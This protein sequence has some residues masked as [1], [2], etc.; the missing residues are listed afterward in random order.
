MAI[1]I[2]W[3]ITQLRVVDQGDLKNVAMQACF[4]VSGVDE[5]DHRGFAQGDVLLLPVSDPAKFA[6]ISTVSEEQV[7]AWVRAALGDRVSFFEGQ[8]TDQIG[9]QKQPKPQ[10]ADLPWL[11]TES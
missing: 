2:T 9:W 8:V 11:K 5:A 3:K 10:P 1:T 6:D 4:D 7:I